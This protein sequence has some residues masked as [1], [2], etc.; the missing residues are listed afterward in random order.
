M[1]VALSKIAVGNVLYIRHRR[2]TRIVDCR[3]RPIY[4]TVTYPVKI[5]EIDIDRMYCVYFMFQGQRRSA[6]ISFSEAGN[7]SVSRLFYTKEKALAK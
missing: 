5:Q 4:E 3:R 1:S 6:R 7:G 2:Q